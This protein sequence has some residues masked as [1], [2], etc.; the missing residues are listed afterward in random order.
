M[1]CN[2]EVEP[3]GCRINSLIESCLVK[4][5]FQAEAESTGSLCMHDGI[6]FLC[7]SE[8]FPLHEMIMGLKE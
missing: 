5:F 6:S 1:H 3:L 2:F 4:I 8:L 7:T